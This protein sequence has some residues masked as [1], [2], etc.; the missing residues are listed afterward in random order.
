MYFGLWDLKRKIRLKRIHFS[1]FTLYL[2]HLSYSLFLKVRVGVGLADHVWQVKRA[3]IAQTVD[4]LD[5]QFR[6]SMRAGWLSYIQQTYP[7]GVAAAAG[8]ALGQDT[9]IVPV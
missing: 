1:L 9:L 5:D 2:L 7:D 4:D 8:P 6:P 3:A